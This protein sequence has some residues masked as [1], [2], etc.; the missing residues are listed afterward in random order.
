MDIGAATS[1]GKDTR[2]KRY[3]YRQRAAECRDL[4][5]EACNDDSRKELLDLANIWMALADT[6]HAP[7]C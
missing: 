3:E 4:A 1:A 6:R 7:A 5:Q 2:G